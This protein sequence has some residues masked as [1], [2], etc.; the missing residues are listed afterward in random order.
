MSANSHYRAAWV[1]TIFTQAV[2]LFHKSRKSPEVADVPLSDLARQCANSVFADNAHLIVGDKELC[3]REFMTHCREN[4]AGEIQ[5]AIAARARADVD[6]QQQEAM[7][8]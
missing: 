7:A 6:S 1:K 4:F 5:T 3:A 2:D 8:S